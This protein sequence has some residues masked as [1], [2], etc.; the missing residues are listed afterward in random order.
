[1]PLAI[2]PSSYE[3]TRRYLERNEMPPPERVRTED[4]LAAMDYD[5][6]R[7]SYRG[8]GLTVT[9]G[10]S[11]ISG[12][13]FLLLQVGVQAWQGGTASHAPLH[14]V[15]LVDTSTSMRWGS[16]ME[17]VRRAL[18]RLPELLGPDD[19][20]SLVSFNQAAHV[21]V[22]NLGRDATSQFRVAAASLTAEGSTN[23]LDGLR[24]ASSVARQWL[25]PNRPAVR[26]VLLT[27]GLL[28][29]EPDIVA[30][31]EKDLAEAAQQGIHFDA[32]DL[33]QQVKDADPQLAAMS[34]AGQGGVHPRL[35][36]SRS[37]G[38]SA[39]SSPAARS[40]SPARPACE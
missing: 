8:L 29:L 26:M 20:V 16:R 5:Y 7:P 40:W 38:R 27:D 15:L 31:V 36:P 17:I 21:L 24:E 2:E 11:P 13:G 3:L 30:K 33:G 39:R 23:F 37:A 19:R 28:D 6:P 18:E 34:L 1:M 35:A 32:I 4:F 12:E 10:Q 22:E 25:G 9:G 14:L